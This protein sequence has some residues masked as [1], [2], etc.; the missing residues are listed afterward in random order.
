ME[1]NKKFFR[2]HP[3]AE[4]SGQK[5]AFTVMMFQK[6]YM[7]KGIAE[8]RDRF[9]DSKDL[10]DEEKQTIQKEHDMV[11]AWA[12]EEIADQ[13]RKLHQPNDMNYICAK[14]IRHQEVVLPKLMK[15]FCTSSVSQYL[16]IASI[17]MGCADKKYTDQLYE[18]Y[19]YIVSDYAKSLACVVFG[20]QD[21]KDLEDF[22]AGE[23]AR[24]EGY[25]EDDLKEGPLIALAAFHG[26]LK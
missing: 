26:E 9:E 21:R 7:E 4:Y 24:Y 8:N 16:E 15:R 13:L 18:N 6:L 10:T 14:A 22:L 11:D 1:I 20:F 5:M 19:P 2:T 25:G 3:I 23:Y 12:P 17:I